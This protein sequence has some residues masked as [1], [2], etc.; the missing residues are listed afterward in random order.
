MN[1]PYSVLFV[2]SGVHGGRKSLYLRWLALKYVAAGVAVS[3]VR[4][5]KLRGAGDELVIIEDHFHD[6]APAPQAVKERPTRWPVP[7]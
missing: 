4:A 7:R 3:V 5:D 2:D 1:K 6:E